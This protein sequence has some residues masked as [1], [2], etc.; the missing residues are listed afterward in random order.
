MVK[1]ILILFLKIKLKIILQK[2]KKNIM[3]KIKIK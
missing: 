1:K 2:G 3:C